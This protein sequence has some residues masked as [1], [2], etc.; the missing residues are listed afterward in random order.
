MAKALLQWGFEQA[1]KEHLPTLV[2]SVPSAW[3]LYENA[4]FERVADWSM[5]YPD[6]DMQGQETG[7]KRVIELVVGVRRAVP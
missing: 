4:G 2:E 5:E 6:R 1:A 3:T 7:E